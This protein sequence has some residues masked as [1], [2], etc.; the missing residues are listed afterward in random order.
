ME[1][2]LKKINSP[3]DLK[4]I[5]VKEL[6]ELSSEIREKII[7]VV[8]K[9]G[10]HLASSLGAVELTIA[11]HYVFDMPKDKI[12]WDVGHQSYAHKILTGREKIFDTLRQLGG[13]SG[14]PNRNESEYD[15]FTCGHSSTSVS[16][17]LGLACARDL[18]SEDAKIIPVIGDASLANG[19]AFEALNHAGHLR[20]DL[21]LVLNDN[22]LSISKSVGAL[23]KYLNKI[24]TNPVYNTVRRRMQ[25][26]VKRLPILGF[27]AFNA[28]KKLEESLKGLLVPGS[29]FEE[30]GFRYFGPING[31]NVSD[32]V[33]TFSNIK[34]LKEPVIVHVVTKKGKGYKPAEDNPSVFHGAP[35]FNKE[36]G[37]PVKNNKKGRVE[38]GDKTFTDIFGDKIAE[39]ARNDDKI[40][41]I[42]AAMVDGTG[43]SRF[44]REFP[45]RFYDVGISEEHG[46]AF[47]AGLARGGLKPVVAIYSTFLQRGYDQII[48]DVSLQK[49]PVV[50]CLDRAGIVGEDGATHH[51]VFDLAY[52]RHIPELIVMAPRDGLEFESM[53]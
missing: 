45:N 21:M 33:S 2:L 51:G 17:A 13:I 53:L 40:V 6:P 46:V 5:P 16:T 23:S 10:G 43:L 42:T 20:K 19:M 32:L 48:H 27:K 15:I 36:T 41:A 1:K 8:S 38:K 12:I 24:M 4:A 35:C 3:K 37:E 14:F 18:K 39:L 29:L 28:A 44:S 49:L 26:L 7:D 9:T 47:G 34:N 50:F 30:L 31:H 22:E 11:L 25:I 52:L